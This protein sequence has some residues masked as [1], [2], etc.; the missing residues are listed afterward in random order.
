MISL[1]NA[2]RNRLIE[3]EIRLV[4]EGRDKKIEMGKVEQ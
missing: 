2:E 3:I 1:N 4:V